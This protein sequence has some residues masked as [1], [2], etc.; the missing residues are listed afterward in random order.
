MPAHGI[1]DP[2]EDV[3]E[4]QI[5]F[6]NPVGAS[7]RP[8]SGHE[9]HRRIEW[10]REEIAE[11]SDAESVEDQADAIIDL[12]YFAFGYLVEMGVPPSGVWDAV[13]KA[14]MTKLWPDGVHTNEIGKVIK[15]PNWVGPEE[16]IRDYIHLLR[17]ESEKT[18]HKKE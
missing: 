2:F 18:P 12:M 7:P 5:A 10:M 13:H 16:S 3:K 6:G 9:K 1:N 11:L 8:L 14:N 4:F 15:P 17:D